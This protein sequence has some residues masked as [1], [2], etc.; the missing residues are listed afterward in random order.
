MGSFVRGRP[1]V[2]SVYVPQDTH[3]SL[4]W[5]VASACLTEVGIFSINISINITI[6]FEPDGS[7][8][9]RV[10]IISILKFIFVELNHQTVHLILHNCSAP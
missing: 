3:I 4:M 6:D 5:V 8:D 10:Y 2:A 1:Q 9:P 7:Y